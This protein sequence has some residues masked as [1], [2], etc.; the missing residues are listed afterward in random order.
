M[1]VLLLLSMILNMSPYAAVLTTTYNHG[2]ISMSSTIQMYHTIQPSDNLAHFGVVFHVPNDPTTAVW[3][4]L[5]IGEPT[6]GGMKG[7]DIVSCEFSSPSSRQPCTINDRYVPYTSVLSMTSPHGLSA[8]EMGHMYPLIDACD[9]QDWM[10]VSSFRNNSVI[11]FEVQ[12]PLDHYDLN[13]RPILPGLSSVLAAHGEMGHGMMRFHG[14]DVRTRAARQLVLYEQPDIDLEGENDDHENLKDNT[15]GL[16]NDIVQWPQD[17]HFTVDLTQKGFHVLYGKSNHRQKFSSIA[18][19]AT[20]VDLVQ[21]FP[22]A[23]IIAAEPI[24][25]VTASSDYADLDSADT[26][27]TTSGG[28]EQNKG[29]HYNHGDA[30]DVEGL[31]YHRHRRLQRIIK[32]VKAFVCSSE[33]YAQRLLDK[34]MD[35][36]ST[37][38]GPVGNPD[39]ECTTFIYG[40]KSFFPRFFASRK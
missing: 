19:T 38:F 22:N 1:L 13:D 15:V 18:C 2:P 3:V 39:S 24:I 21:G 7:A 14:T 25:N 9:Q 31:E 10:L 27:T 12:R 34:S 11:A 40:C 6:S 29:S 32:Y 35:C 16:D 23:M 37:V 26:T 5:G 4:G 20:K 30:G 33:A 17:T 36:T 28:N 8:S